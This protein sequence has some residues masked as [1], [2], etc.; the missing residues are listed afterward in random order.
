MMAKRAC[1]FHGNRALDLILSTLEPQS[2]KRIGRSIRGFDNAIWE[3][4]REN[5]VL[6]G[7]LA[8]FSQNSEMKHHLLGTGNKLLAEASPFD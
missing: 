1:L 4:E 5:A 6:A 8:K 2:H 7:T 3:R